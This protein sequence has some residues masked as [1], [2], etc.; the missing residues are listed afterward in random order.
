MDSG[1]DRFADASI[2]GTAFK[3]LIDTGASKSVMSIPEMIR[4]QLQY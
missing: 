1:D 2:N 3:F 4:P